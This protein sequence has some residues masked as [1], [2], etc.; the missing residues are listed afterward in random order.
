MLV[1]YQRLFGD[2]ITGATTECHWL[3][4]Y[5]SEAEFTV[6]MVPGTFD[7]DG[8]TKRWLRP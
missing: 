5:P 1:I 4:W 3:D 2:G 8:R 7:D 6:W